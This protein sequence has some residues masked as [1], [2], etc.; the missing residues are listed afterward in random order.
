MSRL[1][2]LLLVFLLSGC[3]MTQKISNFLKL[4]TDNSEPPAPLVEF[5]Q[6]INVINL[7]SKS[8]GTG[9]EEQY[10]HLAPVIANQ[11]LYIVDINGDLKALDATNGEVLWTQEIKTNL[12]SMLKFWSDAETEEVTGGPGF[13]EDTV[14]VG[15]SQG[16]VIAFSST[17]GKKLWHAQVTSEVLSPPQMHDN[18]VVV[19]TL[20]GK[21]FALD[22]N[23][24]R[25]LWVYNRSVPTLTLRGTSAPVI[26]GQTIIAGFDGG[27]LAALDLKTGRQLW[28]VTVSESRGSNDLE[29]MVDIDATPVVSNGV[30]FVSTYQGDLV[31]LQLDTGREIWRKKVS[32]YAGFSVD[33]NNVYISDEESTIRAFNRNTGDSVWKQVKLHARGVTAPALI[34]DYLVVG[35]SQGYLHWMQ[36]DSGNF[37]A[38]TKFCDKRIVVKPVVVG[39]FLYAYCSNGKLAAYTYH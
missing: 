38:R 26:S 3:G 22:G 15:T 23:S 27:R 9:T 10:L 21:I 35:D 39:K 13:G 25:R 11:K 20:D 36:K 17:N 8:T 12:P 7:W 4:D 28:E 6:E 1:F 37:V 33:K 16:H 18:I 31:A 29:R 24:G 5:R 2:I 19:R 30:V 32:S 34:D 14:L